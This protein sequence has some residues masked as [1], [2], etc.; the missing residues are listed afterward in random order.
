MSERHFSAKAAAELQEE[1]NINKTLIV[2][3][4]ILA[5]S[6]STPP[7][8]DIESDWLTRWRDNAR[9]VR[10]EELQQLW[11]QALAGEVKAPGTYSLRTLDFLKNIS[12]S[13]AEMISRLAPFVTRD[14]I[15]LSPMLEENGINFLFLL[16]MEDIGVISG[17]TRGGHTQKFKLIKAENFL[18]VIVGGSKALVIEHP[19]PK[20]QL[21]MT[22][23]KLSSI[24]MEVLS[25]GDFPKNSEH[26]KSV[27]MQIKNRGFVVK[28]AD[29]VQAKDGGGHYF[30]PVEL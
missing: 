20:N 16:E 5:N 4:Q 27:G 17:V 6:A 18:S 1:I 8:E 22:C 14:L 2:A 3:E 11:A 7:P 19:A 13:E 25:L 10:S 30:N 29:W 26:L 24:G 12:K 21:R 9:K 28:L 23:Y 15:Y